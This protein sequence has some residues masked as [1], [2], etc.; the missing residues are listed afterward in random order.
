MTSVSYASRV[1]L[2]RLGQVLQKRDRSWECGDVLSEPQRPAAVAGAIGS[3]TDPEL[4]GAGHER[5][6]DARRPRAR[7]APPDS[8]RVSIR[9][10]LAPTSWLGDPAPIRPWPREGRRPAADGNGR[11][12]R[13]GSAGSILDTV[14]SSAVRDPDRVRHQTASP[15]GPLPSDVVV[16]HDPGRRR[17]ALSTRPA[18]VIRHPDRRRHSAASAGGREIERSVSRPARPGLGI[19]LDQRPLGRV[20][21]P[22]APRHRGRSQTAR[23]P[24]SRTVW[25]TTPVPGSMR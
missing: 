18:F 4:V 24:P 1:E 23:S 19:D 6:S 20:R 2:K 11:H 14:A 16:R 21:R 5:R 22:R 3:G 25:V 7:H 9:V 17:P 15:A 12:D 8:M 10:T 13:A